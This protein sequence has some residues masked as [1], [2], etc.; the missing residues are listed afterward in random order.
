[1]VRRMERAHFV[2]R[3]ADPDDERLTRVFLAEKGW[4]VRAD[5]E[6]VWQTLESETFDSVEGADRERLHG[7][8]MRM[9]ENLIGVTEGGHTA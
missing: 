4:S 7:L 2:E 8:L 1:M 9:R 5:V 6:R 3:R